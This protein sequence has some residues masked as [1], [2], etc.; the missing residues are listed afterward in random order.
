MKDYITNKMSV[1]VKKPSTLMVKSSPNTESR[2]VQKLQ[3]NTSVSN[4][5]S[6]TPHKR[7]LIIGRESLLH[8][9]P[10]K[11]LLAINGAVTYRGGK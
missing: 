1:T 7:R 10:N 4:S 2:T 5:A 3:S 11:P 9:E 6:Q 8:Y